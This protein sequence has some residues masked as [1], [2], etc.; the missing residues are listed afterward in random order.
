[1]LVTR[2]LYVDA[3][4]A[5]QVVDLTAAI[6]AQP[7]RAGWDYRI[8]GGLEQPALATLTFLAGY[9]T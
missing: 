6:G 3:A 7:Y 1:V 2:V 9:R 8:F 4:G 5:S